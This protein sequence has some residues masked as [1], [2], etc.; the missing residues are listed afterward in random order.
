MSDP[1]RLMAHEYDGIQEYDNPLP[2]WW[3]AF[4]IASIVFAP[5][6]VYWFHLGG[7]GKSIHEEF[8]RDWASYQAWKAEAEK[9]HAL[10]V[11]ED[12]LASMAKDPAVL[13]A[14]RAI[15]AE[16]CVGCHMDDARGNIGAN[17]TD[18]YQIHGIS[19]LD[20]Y[21]TIRD[22]VPDKGMISWG[23]TMQP[24][25]MA[26]VAAYVS[27]LRVHPVANGKAPQGVKVGPF[28]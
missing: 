27:T 16:K 26:T 4:F 15:F 17:L 8:D 9:T 18:D 10:N 5:I 12:V 20:L 25:E 21:Q 6:Y 11:T 19:R 14:G 2:G 7:P 1:D 22:G 3:K 13:T 24:R 28:E 23:A